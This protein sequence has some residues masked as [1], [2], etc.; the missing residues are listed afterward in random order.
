MAF[1]CED[2]KASRSKA[3]GGIDWYRYNT[4]ILVPKLLP[5]AQECMVDRPDTLVQE[6]KAPAHAHQHQ[7]VVF[8]LA[9]VSRLLW[10]GNSPDLNAIEPAWP[11]MKRYTTKKGAPKSRAEAIKAWGEAWYTLPQERI[12]RWIERLPRHIEEI[13]RLEGDIEYKEGRG[14]KTR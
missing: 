8:D 7:Q 9:G 5:F 12:Q 3:K 2:W 1:Y 14:Y 11:W 4:T 13:I 6:D 10:P